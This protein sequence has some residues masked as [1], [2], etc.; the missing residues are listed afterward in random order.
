MAQQCFFP[1]IRYADWISLKDRCPGQ[2]S[3]QSWLCCVTVLHWSCSLSAGVARGI[4]ER[5]WVTGFLVATCSREGEV[6]EVRQP[7]NFMAYLK[8]WL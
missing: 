4:Y 2:V 3:F 7:A 5:G 1:L 6:R 8:A